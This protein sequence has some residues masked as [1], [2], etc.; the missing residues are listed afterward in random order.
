MYIH[1]FRSYCAAKY[2]Y[3][4]YVFIGPVPRSP[5][6]HDSVYFY[7]TQDTQKHSL[8]PSIRSG[9][10]RGLTLRCFGGS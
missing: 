6:Q 3:I 5:I 1:K 7:I 4:L 9:I 8:L 10:Y 2:T